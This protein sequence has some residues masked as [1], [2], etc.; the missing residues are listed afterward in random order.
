MN[1]DLF[2][3]PLAEPE[4]IDDLT[5]VDPDV[6]MKNRG[7]ARRQI[8]IQR[9]FKALQANLYDVLEDDEQSVKRE[10]RIH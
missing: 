3:D 5:S 10:R 9:E 1:V 6:E 7:R 8:E 4:P 2:L